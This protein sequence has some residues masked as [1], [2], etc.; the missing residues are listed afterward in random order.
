MSAG[1]IIRPKRQAR[2]ALEGLEE[3]AML[4]AKPAAALRAASAPQVTDKE[5]RYTTPGGA[6]VDVAL[7]GLG[8]L[9]GTTVDPDGAL[10]LRFQGTN[11]QTGIV[12]KVTGGN[13]R[14]PLRTLIHA[15]LPAASVSGIGSSLVNVVN[16]KGFDLVE[17]GRVNLT[18]GVHTFFLNSVAANTEVQLR[19]IPPALLS[20][21]S[22]TSANQNGVTLGFLADQA[23]AQSLT[24]TGGSFVAGI[25]LVSN[26]VLTSP[27]PNQHQAPPGIVAV[28]NDVNGPARPQ[29]GLG[30]PQ[31]FGYDPAVNALIRFDVDTGAPTLTIPNALPAGGIQAGVTLARNSGKLVVLVSD[32]VAVQAYNPL[33]GSKVGSFSVANLAAGGLVSPTKLG[34]VDSFTVIGDPTAGSNGNGL[35]QILDVTRSLA[36]G[37]AVPVGVPFSAQ[38]EFGLSGGMTGVPGSSTLYAVGGAHFDSFQPDKFQLGVASLAPSATPGGAGFRETSRTA[39]TNLGQTLTTNAKGGTPAS[40]DSA[41]ASVDLNLA[42]ITSSNATTNTVTL[43]SPTS[44]SKS[45]TVTLNNPNQL[46]GISWV[47]RP[48]LAGSALVDVQGNIQSFRAHTT[49]GLVLS[50]L[51]N[52]NLLKIDQA[53]DTT[54]VAYPFGH[55]EIGKRTNVTIA[56]SKRVVAGRN[57]VTDMPA[58]TPTGPLSLP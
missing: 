29:A 56:S 15:A 25:N 4:D 3:R 51:G 9:K 11:A 10:N 7:Y 58:L 31:I 49:K 55:A 28:I 38:R 16:L 18:G 34:N 48:A 53:V 47:L 22:T 39:V 35:I 54:V 30:A 41:F 40:P 27:K 17:G 57:G 32:G 6:R 23:G 33:D 24:G 36:T 50:D 1:S 52:L 20:S 19:E 12:G 42:L 2:P 8:S 26:T 13:G 44:F 37:Q 5:V 46:S 45:G 14:A 21:S 43:Y